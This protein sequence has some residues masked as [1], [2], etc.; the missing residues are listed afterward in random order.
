MVQARVQTEQ[1]AALAPGVGAV[2]VAPLIR[3]RV[4]VQPAA[5]AREVLSAV[6][7]LSKPR[8]TR[9]VALTAAVGYVLGVYG[10]G[11]GMLE[12]LLVGAGCIA[13]TALSAGGA[14]ALNQWWERERDAKM[15]RT[16]TR[17]L[18]RGT[19][20]P[21]LALRAG[22]LMG[23]LGVALLALS[24]GAAAAGV[25]ALTIL[26]Y[27]LVYTPSKPV[28]PLNT[29]IGAVPGALPPLIGWCAAMTVGGPAMEA[30]WSSLSLSG[31]AGG[32][33]AGGWS[34]F[35]LMFVWQLPHFLAIAWMHK[36]DYALGGH[37]MLPWYDPT[38]RWT[39]LTVLVTG[40]TL[41]PATLLPVR[42]IPQV[43]GV[44]YAVV[45]L[46][47]GLIFAGLCLRLLGCIVRGD[48]S[49]SAARTVFLASIIHLPILLTAM[50]VEV[51]VRGWQ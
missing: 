14:N 32:V 6:V 13:G 40:L 49:R 36:D 23:V 16:C 12:M 17:P 37:R 42:A 46:T 9:L 50:M 3:T 27:V 48:L 22:V 45:A 47:T 39:G 31:G 5:G 21:A 43:L 7:E 41:L 34:L 26:T 24:S 44:G 51:L 2:I 29:L 4:A 19:I 35:V 18:P 8:I 28:T 11:A 25:S 15:M 10:R 1:A 38:G 30:W 33:G 20:G